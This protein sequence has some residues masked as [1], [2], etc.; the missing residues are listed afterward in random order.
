M[1]NHFT[2][3]RFIV[4][5]GAAAST[6][7]GSSLFK[8]DTVFAAPYIRRNMGGMTASDPVLV[9]YR[10]AIKAMKLLPT[11]NP[12]S[13]NYQAAIHGTLL[14]GSYTSW[15]TCEHG[16]PYFWSW[17]RM[18]LYWF[19]RI[20]RKMSGDSSWALPYWDYISPSQRH[21]PAPFQ[22]SASEL[23]F[24]N[25]GTG[26]NTGAASYAAWQVDPTSGNSFTDYFSGQ[27]GLESN[28]H[29]NV[30]VYM[31]GAMGNPTTAAA[32]PIFYV[33][34]SNIDRLWNLWLA[35][36]GGRTDP[37]TTASW[38]NKAYTFFDENGSAVNMKTCDILRAAEQL[39]YT[40]ESEPSQV[41]EYCLEIIRFPIYYLI[42]EILIHWPGPPVEL[43]PEAVSIPIE[44]KEVQQR[45]QQL[46]ASEKE[47]LLLQLDNVEAERQP[48]VVWQ[49]FLG[50]PPNAAPNPDSPFFLGTL[51]LFSAGVRNQQHGEAKTAHFTFRANRA[52]T[53]A[54]RMNQ[55]Q[56]RLVFVPT[57][58][59]IDG[60]PS[61]PKVEA[62]VRIGTIN[63]SIGREKTDQPIVPERPPNEKLEP[64]V[65]PKIDQIKPK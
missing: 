52:V 3:R 4:T 13:W 1:K 60:K 32:D 10:K 8:L 19:E 18:Y 15:N 51:A 36:G 59:L 26:W 47:M 43:G 28:P 14:S 20:I 58:P 39:N 46:A 24:S 31:G 42:Q 5:A 16:T 45:L 65:Q 33:H 48:G 29:D 44:I 9:S 27:G 55:G 54:L 35:Q 53:E 61:R 6:V 7:L 23:Y 22:D 49:V 63:L 2:R 34:H 50:L 12:L 30:H 21:L 25:R 40:Y 17:H 41:K 37:L 11:S 57:G 62:P 56:L 64:K 38:R